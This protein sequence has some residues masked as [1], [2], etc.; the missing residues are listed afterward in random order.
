MFHCSRPYSYFF[1][2]WLTVLVLLAAGSV[3]AA[4]IDHG[5]STVSDT[6]T[7]L[8]WDQ[9]SWGQ[10]GSACS[11]G[12]ASTHTW[13]EA[14][15]VAVS[16]RASAYKGHQ[17]WRL[18][19]V[20]E[21]ESLVKIDAY[22]PA[23]DATA[24]PNTPFY[25]GYWSSTINTPDPAFAWGVNFD[26][27]DTYAGGQSFNGGRVRLVRSG[28]SV[29]SFDQATQQVITFAPTP[30]FL[31]G[32]TATLSATG[33]ASGLPVVFSSQTPT[34]CSVA[35]S[36]VTG[37][38]AGTC[39]VAANQAGNSTWPAAVEKTQSFAVTSAPKQVIDNLLQN[40][41]FESGATLWTQSSKNSYPLIVAGTAN[42]PA[43]GGSTYAY[44]GGYDSAS[45]FIEQSLTIPANASPATL[46]F[47]TQITTQETS[48]TYCDT[49]SV[50]LY[51][52]SGQYL[53]QLTTLSG[54]NASSGWVKNSGFDLTTYQG[55]TVR[56]RFTAT[57]NASNNT[58]FLIDDIKLS[59]SV[60]YTQSIT[61][62]PAPSVLEGGTGSIS[63]SASSGLPVTLSSSTTRTCVL[64]GTTVTGVSPGTCTITANQAGDTGYLPA[65]PATL[66]FNITTPAAIVAPSP[67][68]MTSI[69]SGRGS[70]TLTLTAPSSNG[71][72]AIV[73][74]AATCTANNQPT[75]T[76]SGSGLTLTVRGL[77]GGVAYSCTATARN[78]LHTSSPSA[79]QSVTPQ[80]GGSSLTPILMLLFE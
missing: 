34:I 14:Q 46:E 22:N 25:F 69:T 67:P 71:G 64:S 72:A 76:A 19:N 24:F 50:E 43:H 66:N 39:T 70:A 80:T 31:V 29:D 10:S 77:K 57:T 15:G 49:L 54:Q 8:I 9:C 42:L 60:L 51:N 5:D 62:G 75:K 58:R 41:G 7:G 1:R 61:F 37:V 11:S 36:S 4:L 73:A 21:L 48:C 20:A 55:Q 27:G 17:D 78:T 74:Y 28:Q 3:H 16:A 52:A 26:Y 44:L 56:L 30:S 33:G 47:W 40:S 68:G 38:A 13:K 32:G 2:L 45:D 65:P 63:A 18:P 12:S 53:Q 23:I 6:L 59:A 35:D 79:A